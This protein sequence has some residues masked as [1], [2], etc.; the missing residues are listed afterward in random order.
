[1]PPLSVDRPRIRIDS[2]GAAEC[3]VVGDDIAQN[4]KR[5]N[6]S[7]RRLCTTVS[8]IAIAIGEL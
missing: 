2:H 8:E 3:G 5:R 1:M 7:I 6:P 4:I